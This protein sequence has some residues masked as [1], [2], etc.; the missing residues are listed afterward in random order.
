[1]FVTHKK[2]YN[3]INVFKVL[4]NHLNIYIAMN[5]AYKHMNLLRISKFIRNVL[6]TS[7][8]APPAFCRYRPPP[9]AG[10]YSWRR[11]I[12]A[13][14]CRRS[15]WRRWQPPLW[16]WTNCWISPPCWR[17]LPVLPEIPPSNETL[18]YPLF[19]FPNP[20]TFFF[21]Q[22]CRNNLSI[23]LNP[24]QSVEK[25]IQYSAHAQIFLS[26]GRWL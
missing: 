5:I 22:I 16:C 24:L 15:C 23:K 26:H 6:L 18:E 4:K 2:T 17:T 8:E 10:V 7:L 20:S 21:L 13:P 12:P 3:N 1:M 25:N 14:H 9:P 11:G 19:C